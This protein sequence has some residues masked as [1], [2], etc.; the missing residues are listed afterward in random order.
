M[1]GF[2][3]S[4]LLAPLFRL[5]QI[6][7]EQVA[8][9]LSHSRLLTL[10]WVVRAPLHRRLAGWSALHE[11]L[12]RWH[13]L[14]TM[15]IFILAT[16]APTELIGVATTGAF[17]FLVVRWLVHPV[18]FTPT[19]IDLLV[20]GFF[21][22]ALIA[23]AFSSY[24][25]TSL[26]GLAKFAV[27]L[28][29]YLNFRVL[30]EEAPRRLVWLLGLLMVLG[31]GQATVAYYQYR[32]G[33]QPL[34]T[35]Q[36]PS[37]N[38]ELQM[39]R[40]WG[41]L[42]PYNPNLLAGF[43]IPCVSAGVGLMWLALLTGRP[44]LGTMLAG[45]ALFT[46]G[47]LVLTGSRG[48]YLALVGMMGV[49]YAYLGH[50]LWRE[51]ALKGKHT[52]RALWLAS[53]IAIVGAGA[54]ALS[55][56]PALQNR[57]LSIFALRE[58][59]SN[60]FRMNVWV[61]TWQMIKDNWWCGIG[62]GNE[63]FRLVYGLYMVPGYLALASYSVPLQIWVEQGIA[64]L[65]FFILLIASLLASAV[66]Q[67]HRSVP[68]VQKLVV[69]LLAMGI[70]GSLLYGAF[71]T[72]WY[73]PAVNLTFWLMVAGMVVYAGQGVRANP[74]VE[75]QG[76]MTKIAFLNFGGIGDELLFSPVIRAV[77]SVLPSAHLTLILEGRSRSASELIPELDETIP[78]QVQGVSR[79]RL[80][81][82]LV[83][84]LRVGQYDAVIASGSSPFIPIALALSGVP[85]RVG[86]D[87]G[88]LSRWL[89][90]APAELNTRQYAGAMYF[91]L[92]RAF[93]RH[94]G[95][96]THAQEIPRPQFTPTAEHRARGLQLLEEAGSRNPALRV[97]IHPGVSK[98]SVEKNILKAWAPE[99][100]VLFVHQLAT[101]HPS[102][103]II[104]LGG[105]DDEEVIH[106]IETALA[107]MPSEVRQRVFN[108][109]GRTQSLM[110]LA[111]VLA[112]AD[113]FVCVDSA[114]MHLAVALQRPIVAIFAP[115]D[116][117]KLLPQDER[118]QV[119]VREDVPCRPCLWDH[120]NESCGNPICLQVPV[121][122]VLAKVERLLAQRPLLL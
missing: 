42:Q 45:C 71:D 44:L 84:L 82:Q 10:V 39:T 58:D 74:L 37:L 30:I 113:V 64:G 38:P 89:L 12:Q 17:A 26:V 96:E 110:D 97:M 1:S 67:F 6:P 34:A 94:I 7:P 29:G 46:L 24:V 91:A 50:L 117:K 95:K 77:R 63:T 66:V 21:A 40:V 70:V 118:F 100:W 47:A 99:N 65:L 79:V 57:V 69:G 14:A 27:F 19:V 59:S 22:T 2:S 5:V 32:M 120:R 109:Y 33:V 114:P 111:C 121:A 48:S 49:M 20:M 108:L 103:H 62:L 25:A 88:M 115:T 13:W 36:D 35:W 52:L 85:I 76:A 104:L 80:F 53:L 75:R 105:P 11:A 81:W 101:R 98:V 8:R 9:W 78:I 16:F 43:L 4:L 106:A 107:R 92:V 83:R 55:V 86:Y 61:A 60:A 72:I 51:P 3:N 68:L 73:R 23:T 41:T 93:L 122:L 56:S 87:T 18:R 31:F 28:M 15:S 112:W 119:A 90:T 116:E 54:I 102:L